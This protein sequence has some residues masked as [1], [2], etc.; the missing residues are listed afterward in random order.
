MDNNQYLQS[1]LKARKLTDTSP[2]AAQL[3]TRR[4]EVEAVLKAAFPGVILSIRYAGSKIKGTMIRDSYDLD[5][6]CYFPCDSTVAGSSLEEIYTSVSDALASGGFSP[7]EKTSAIRLHK[8]DT[9]FHVDV[10]P[11][12]FFDELKTDVWLHQTT[13]TKERLK[14]NLDTHIREI[15]DSGV[16]DAICLLKLWRELYSIKQAK[17]FILELLVVKI[18]KDHKRDSL[19]AQLKLVLETFRD[20]ADSLTVEDPA[21]PSGN[22]LS[23]AINSM[24]S[25]LQTMARQALDTERDGGWG[26]VFGSLGDDSEQNG[27]HL[28]PPDRPF[29]IQNPPKPWSP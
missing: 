1:L 13:G 25:S 16:V 14:T 10:V 3:E 2:E 29:I 4:V 18:L 15:R 22:I 23:D 8:G 27:Y 6:T 19:D 11:G 21:N 20:H 24:R 9:D 17:T 7:E 5:L 28:K 12:R 26:K